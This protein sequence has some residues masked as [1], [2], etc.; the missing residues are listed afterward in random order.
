MHH[1]ESS[2]TG[3]G[4]RRS[5]PSIGLGFSGGTRFN[6]A[7]ISSIDAS[8]DFHPSV[9]VYAYTCEDGSRE[10]LLPLLNLTQDSYACTALPCVYASTLLTLFAAPESHPRFIRLHSCCKSPG[11]EPLGRA[12]HGWLLSGGR[13]L[14]L[15]RCDEWLPL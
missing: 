4:H 10:P 6:R 14:K 1:A 5:R 13:P 15:F 8:T 7:W 12:K 11:G 9:I 2:P 3:S